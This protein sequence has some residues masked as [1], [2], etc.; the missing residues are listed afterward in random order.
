MMRT[1]ETAIDIDRYRPRL[2][3]VLLCIIFVAVFIFIYSPGITGA[4]ADLKVGQE[5]L[6]TY[7]S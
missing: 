7:I 1:R 6:F 5:I 4:G 2:Q 3:S